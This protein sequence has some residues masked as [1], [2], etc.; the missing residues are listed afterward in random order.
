M[1]IFL[2]L[3]FYFMVTG[4]KVLEV[5]PNNLKQHVKMDESNSTSNI[6]E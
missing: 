4:K 3:N 5:Y 6:N 2:L 1:I